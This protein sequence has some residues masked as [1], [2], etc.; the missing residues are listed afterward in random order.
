MVA[1]RIRAGR[2]DNRLALHRRGLAALL[3]QALGIEG[4]FHGNTILLSLRPP[5]SFNVC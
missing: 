3:D 4:I 2:L 1:S 5:A